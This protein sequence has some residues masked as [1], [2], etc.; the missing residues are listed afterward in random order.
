[1]CAAVQKREVAGL[2][3]EQRL[4]RELAF[5]CF[6]LFSMTA[7]PAAAKMAAVPIVA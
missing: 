2:V 3:L 5:A 4:L 1:V 7:V 6:F